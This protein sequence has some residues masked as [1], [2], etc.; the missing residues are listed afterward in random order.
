MSGTRTAVANYARGHVGRAGTIALRIALA[1]MDKKV[2]DQNLLDEAWTAAGVAVAIGE[3]FAEARA[4]GGRAI[5]DVTFALHTRLG[6]SRTAPATPYLE[7]IALDPYM[8][9]LAP[10]MKE[11]SPWRPVVARWIET[12][13]ERLTMQRYATDAHR[14]LHAHDLITAP[15]AVIVAPTEA[16]I[17][18]AELMLALQDL[19]DAE[20]FIERGWNWI[21]LPGPDQLGGFYALS[22]SARPP[23]VKH[24]GEVAAEV[25]KKLDQH[26]GSQFPPELGE[27]ICETIGIARDALNRR[28]AEGKWPEWPTSEPG[29]LERV[30]AW[31]RRKN[32]KT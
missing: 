17:D 24:I 27:W 22:D 14:R 18:V 1:E 6:L 32:N 3:V 31:L 23:E 4:I 16:M 2:F 7:L 13:N 12:I 28:A 5:V 25:A 19:I 26:L 20:R 8:E 10:K 9:W 11:G 21:D 15:L 30:H 29:W